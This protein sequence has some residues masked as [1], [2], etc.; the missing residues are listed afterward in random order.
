MSEEPLSVEQLQG[1]PTDD[2]PYEPR[3]RLSIETHSPSLQYAVLEATATANAFFAEMPFRLKHLDS[4]STVE[5]KANGEIE[6]ITFS[7]RWVAT[8]FV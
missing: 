4:S 8:S 1:P 7:S 2:E 6:W 5:K 3:Y